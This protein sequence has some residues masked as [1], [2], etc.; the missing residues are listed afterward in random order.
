MIDARYL[1]SPYSYT[2]FHKLIRLVLM[3]GSDQR[4]AE[5]PVQLLRGL[6]EERGKW[7]EESV[8]G[9]RLSIDR[10]I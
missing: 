1:P 4:G 2:A 10:R 6:I 3:A 7:T 5:S 8:V 9:C